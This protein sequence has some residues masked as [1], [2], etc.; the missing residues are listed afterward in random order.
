MLVLKAW[1]GC[2]TMQYFLYSGLS[3][4]SGEFSITQYE[5]LN[6]LVALRVWGHHFTVCNTGYTR[7]KHL[8][9]YSHLGY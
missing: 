7:C 8:V 1:D 2:G 3:K 9:S 6:M 4:N 5:M